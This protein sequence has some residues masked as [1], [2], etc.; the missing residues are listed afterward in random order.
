MAMSRSFGALSLTTWPPIRSSPSVMS[1]SPAIML[2][3]VDFP[4]PDGPDEDHEL[5]V[6]DLEVDVASRPR[7]VGVPLGDVVEHDLGH[8]S[9]LL[10]PL[11]A[12]EVSPATMRRWKSSTKM[13]IGM[14]MITA[15]AAIDPV[16]LLELRRAGEE[17]DGR[18][19]RAGRSRSTSARSRT[20]SRSSRR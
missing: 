20:G 16:G 14:V 13:M 18:R 2:S 11:T 8:R 1:S 9:A 10:Y 7:A 3:V 6:G 17:R 15:A 19:H 5:A 4:Q 12:P